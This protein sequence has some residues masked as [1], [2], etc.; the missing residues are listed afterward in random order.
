[1]FNTLR[2]RLLLSYFLVAF[3]CLSV[4][5]CLILILAGPLQRQLTYSRLLDRA[6]P[7]TLWV[8]E[9]LRRNAPPSEIT[10]RAEVQL[11]QQQLRMFLIN[12]EGLVLADS[13]DELNGQTVPSFDLRN[14]TPAQWPVRGQWKPPGGQTAYYVSLPATSLRAM[15]QP[16]SENTIFVVLA[17]RDRP[18]V[19]MEALPFLIVAVVVGFIVSV[20]LS[21]L[22]A[23]WIAWPLGQVIH[24]E[25]VAGGNYDQRLEI[26][27]PDEMK[28]LA[29]SFNY[30][31]KQVKAAQ[32]SQR[33]FVAN[34]SHELKT[35]LTSIQ[36]FAQAILDG[37]VRD[38]EGQRRAAQ[39]IKEE[40]QRMTRLVEDLLALAKVAADRD[41][42]TWTEVD[43]SALLNSCVQKLAIVAGEKELNFDLAL[44]TVSRARG[45]PDR[46]AQVFTNLLDNA[47]KHSPRRGI[48]RVSTRMAADTSPHRG[49]GQI[50]I[51]VADS[52]PGIPHEDLSRIFERFYQVDKSR[53]SPKGG[54]GLGLAIVHEIVEM[55]DGQI[56]ADN[57]PSSGAIFT[58]RLPEA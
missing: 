6:I 19:L 31:A 4:T 36:G 46:L 11:E 41:H 30:M 51:S 26:A 44:N 3:V 17:T 13:D 12:R 23:H 20:L 39:I 58:V 40:A 54:A 10:Q 1:M 45:N 34:V 49:K 21:L 48:I 52:G 24:V 57:Q 15:R 5:V 37:T 53:A 27:S 33:D 2:S 7:T 29:N 32:D 25:E 38:S 28:R 50:E 14:T 22:I 42:S 55:H 9:L 47:I 16:L 8:Q 43:I 18:R 35:P 56:R